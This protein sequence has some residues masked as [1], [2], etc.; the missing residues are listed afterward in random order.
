MKFF[1]ALYLKNICE[2]SSVHFSMSLYVDFLTILNPSKLLVFAI[3]F[4]DIAARFKARISNPSPFRLATKLLFLPSV[5]S[6][7][8]KTT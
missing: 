4:C 7:D 3:V 5:L 1:D 6:L 2:I 8:A